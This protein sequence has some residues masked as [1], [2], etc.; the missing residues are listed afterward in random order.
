MKKSRILI[1]LCLVALMVFTVAFA[2]CND[3]KQQSDSS[4]EVT[5]SFKLGFYVGTGH[6]P[7]SIKVAKGGEVTLPDV[8][9]EWAGHVF[10][11]WLYG[12]TKYNAGDKVKLDSNASFIATWKDG[13]AV[14]KFD[15]TFSLGDY[16]GD[17]KAP[18]AMKVERGES[19]NLPD[20]DF[21][22]DGYTFDGWTVGGGTRVYPV[23]EEYKVNNDV[24]FQAKWTQIP[25]VTYTVSFDLGDYEDGQ[26][27]ADIVK[28]EGEHIIMPSVSWLGHQFLGWKLGENA[29]LY[30]VNADYVVTGDVT[31]VAQWQVLD[32]TVSFDLG[33]YTGEEEAPEA[34]TG[35]WGDSFQLT[36][37]AQWEEHTFTGWKNLET[38]QTYQA[39][40]DYTIQGTVT[41]TAQWQSV[42]SIDDFAGVWMNSGSQAYVIVGVQEGKLSVK[43]YVN[44]AYEVFDLQNV[45]YD[46]VNAQFTI[47]FRADY[48]GNLLSR[49]LKMV[50]SRL[51]ID[52]G[53]DMS[54]V[55]LTKQT[56]ESLNGK[57]VFH[58]ADGDEEWIELTNGGLVSG[59]SATL[60]EK[61][62]KRAPVFAAVVYDREDE[63]GKIYKLVYRLYA[64]SSGYEELTYDEGFEVLEGGHLWFGNF[65]DMN[66]NRNYRL[67]V[68]GATA[69]AAF[70]TANGASTLFKYTVNDG[71]VYVYRQSQA[72]AFEIVIIKDG[73]VEEGHIFTMTRH[74]VKLVDDDEDPNT[75][76]VSQGKDVDYV[77]KIDGGNLLFASEERGTYTGDEGNLVLDG[78]DGG[79]LDGEPIEYS[80]YNS[81]S[82]AVIIN[83]KSYILDLEGDT[84]TVSDKVIDKWANRVYKK[85]GGAALTFDGF[86]SVTYKTTGT[87]SYQY[88]YEFAEDE[89]IVTINNHGNYVL[90]H[91]F[92]IR[93]DMSGDAGDNFEMD[94][95]IDSS[96][97]GY[98]QLADGKLLNVTKW[99][100]AISSATQEEE[101]TSEFEANE[102]NTQYTFYLGGEQYVLSVAEGQVKVNDADVS[103]LDSF[104]ANNT[105][106]ANHNKFEVSVD[107]LA[108]SAKY[109]VTSDTLDSY[110]IVYKDGKLTYTGY[111]NADNFV[112]AYTFTKDGDDVYLS[113]SSLKNKFAQEH[114]QLSSAK[115]PD[116]QFVY[117]KY[118]MTGN[119]DI[120]LSYTF[121]GGAAK[122][123]L[124]G[125]EH[126]DTYD[127]STSNQS[128]S[129]GGSTVYLKMWGS[130]LQAYCTSSWDHSEYEGEYVFDE[131]IEPDFYPAEWAGRW[132]SADGSIKV[133]ISTKKVQIWGTSDEDWVDAPFVRG[134]GSNYYVSY[135]GYDNVNL[136]KSSSTMS[137]SGGPFTSTELTLKLFGSDMLG[138]FKTADEQYVYITKSGLVYRSGDSIGAATDIVETADNDFTFSYGGESYRVWKDVDGLKLS[139]ASGDNVQALSV[140]Q[141]D[142]SKDKFINPNRVGTHIEFDGCGNFLWSAYED[143]SY[144]TLGYYIVNEDGDY[145]VSGCS[146]STYNGIWKLSK[147]GNV[148]SKDSNNT[149]E[150]V[151]IITDMTE[152]T[153]YLSDLIAVVTKW[154]VDISTPENNEFFCSEDVTKQEDGSYKFSANGTEYT[155]SGSGS[156]LTIKGS[157]LTLF[158]S[159]PI[160]EGEY[161]AYHNIYYVSTKYSRFQ[162][163]FNS[164]Y[165]STINKDAQSLRFEGAA[166]RYIAIL[167]G[168]TYEFSIEGD[169]GAQ[170]YYIYADGAKHLLSTEKESEVD[171]PLGVWQRD[172]D[173]KQITIGGLKEY[174]QQYSFTVDDNVYTT[175]SGWTASYS[176]TF[177]VE[178]SG[179]TYTVNCRGQAL[180][181]SSDGGDLNGAYLLVEEVAPDYFAAS[182]YGKWVTSDGKHIINI[183]GGRTLTYKGEG[184]EQYYEVTIEATSSSNTY[185]ITPQGGVDSGT[186]FIVEISNG[187]VWFGTGSSANNKMS[188]LLFS[189]EM[190]GYWQAEDG[191]YLNITSVSATPMYAAN[192]HSAWASA[193]SISSDNENDVTFTVSGVQYRIWFE[194]EQLKLSLQDGSN[195]Q[196]LTAREADFMKGKFADSSDPTGFYYDF[197]GFGNVVIQNARSTL[198]GTYY[199]NADKNSIVIVGPSSAGSMA[200]TGPLSNSNNTI[201]MG[202]F[203]YNRQ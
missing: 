196:D 126:A 44:G 103:K 190:I 22:R 198:N 42:Y 109:L 90:F 104:V 170:Q 82:K 151:A 136:S 95:T 187:N 58:S 158:D 175:A 55:A 177:T 49:T 108:F 74:E 115:E 52:L 1:V 111:G 146:N 56:D 16:E 144:A 79:T 38:N 60:F 143:N 78:F 163:G 54:N 159:I 87:T 165:G 86:G 141:P 195:P 194:G 37:P 45:A 135:G 110:Y 172:G 138:Y 43:G 25:E 24:A 199:F 65:I 121:A 61:N 160:P 185:N 148:I 147:K 128:I 114:V 140:A 59:M 17:G 48:S 166:F 5:A 182:V 32:Y 184:D 191:Q 51:V 137:I 116:G 88:N 133:R 179:I 97:V 98:Y 155:L 8:G 102:D 197:D 7:A 2:A 6:A 84:Y 10:D 203:P 168:V 150:H 139:K 30:G 13:V 31:F 142:S 169:E 157:E 70:S 192:Y 200:G 64:E 67:F 9:V 92:V 28:G 130:V 29:D 63:L 19:I 164:S 156:A 134:S 34:H 117:G 149:L 162:I 132:E 124:T 15:V 99:Y 118:H 93:F 85:N 41:L 11:G 83:S 89:N 106:Y 69:C 94:A 27:P 131:A 107:G 81:L 20:L 180:Y 129:V 18:D 76:A 39:G 183:T 178:I 21:T 188:R 77:C 174:R 127:L 176:K 75:P 113:A 120:T 33:V 66:G 181:I 23:G 119:E 91:G 123:I 171:Y 47:S 26:A 189:A 153:Y 3:D 12:A 96:V 62:S 73:S 57:Y 105:Y 14:A 161:Y 193:T 40:S 112:A 186:Q 4:D 145:V 173:N 72:T 125:G 68:K 154:Y 122:I 36:A 50:N 53:S 201:T 101:F 71:F 100:F 152:G 202:G 46:S 167:D 80:G 35:H